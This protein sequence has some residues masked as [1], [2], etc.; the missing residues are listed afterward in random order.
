MFSS[1][2]RS[3]SC[4]TR[5]RRRGPRSYEARERR[6]VD[7]ESRHRYAEVLDA[8]RFSGLYS[9]D[10]GS[11]RS[12]RSPSSFMVSPPRAGAGQSGV[13]PADTFDTEFFTFYFINIR[14]FVSHKAELTATLEEHGFPTFVG[15]NETLLPGERAMR[16]IELP[17]YIL[18]SRRDRTDNSGWGGIALFAKSGFENCVVHLGNSEVAERAWHVLHTD[19][20]PISLALW[21]RRPEPGEVASIRSLDAEM[22][23]YG[24]DTVGT[25]LI[26]DLNVHEAS[27]LKYSSGTSVEGRELHEFCSE[28]GLAQ[29]VDGPTREQNLLDLLISDLGSLAKVKIV[30]AIADHCG[31]FAS[32]SFPVPEATT[33]QRQ[34]FLYARA[35]WSTLQ[36]VLRDTDWLAILCANDVDGSVE[37]FHRVLWALICDHIPSEVI[38]ETKTSHEWLDDNCRR[39]IRLKREAWGTLEFVTRRD[40]CTRGLLEAYD[41]FVK[42][43]RSKL[44]RLKRSSRE[45]WRLS[46]ALMSLGSA[47]E[48]VP[49]LKRDD[50]SWSTSA[51]DKADL[52]AEIFADK[53]TLDDAE[54]NEFSDR[55]VAPSVV[56]ADTFVP[57]RRRHVRSVLKQLD[58]NSG[59][60]PDGISTRVLRRC[61]SE[62]EIPMLLLARL[63]FN[64]GKWPSVWRLHWV[65]PI[66]KKKSRADPRN[67]R[68]VHLTPQ[69]SKI[70]E[71]VIGRAFLPWV[72]RNGLFGANQYAYTEKRSHKDALAANVCNWLVMLEQGGTIGLYCSDVTGAF[73]RVR[74]E[75]LVQKLRV[76]GINPRVVRFLES[77]LE[78]RRSVV[79][80]SG[81]QSTPRLL[82]NSVYQGT[83]LGPPLWNL[84]YVDASLA[85]SSLDFSEVVFADDFNC[86]RSFEAST[87]L[88]AVLAECIK[89]QDSLHKWGRANSVKFDPGKES[90]HILH[91]TRGLGD[92]FQLLGL[93]FD[94]ALQM[95]PCISILAREAGWRL[96]SVLRPRRFFST[97]EVF[98]LYK[99][100]VLSY[101][102]SGTAGYYHAAPT[103]LRPLDRVQERLLREIGVSAEEA[104]FRYR[105]APLRSRRDMAM[106]GLLHRIVLGQAP[107]QLIELFPRSGLNSQP[108]TRLGFRRHTFQL[109]QPAFRTDVLQRS[110]FGLTVVYN[111]L[112]PEVVACSSVKIFQR[113]LQ[114]AL[115][116]AANQRIDNWDAIFSPRLRPIRDLYFQRLFR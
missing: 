37:R 116:N 63:V 74:R 40:E 55:F 104:L 18:V 66:Y 70:V 6:R 45:W 97:R 22:A 30:P 46:R 47:A 103:V 10:G 11:S 32:F 89:C 79:V 77:W 35:D 94:V 82:S 7:R 1:R 42:R 16:R 76:S 20:G 84:F 69:I 13:S 99:S 109:V 5:T 88:G 83:V 67:Y 31:L 39:L 78:D 15:L 90:F 101:I 34:V 41:A 113:W 38:S 8:D 61:R 107:P 80:V 86:W 62:L 68:G 21:Y 93:C 26:G 33:V 72:H 2:T 12:P 65:H 3:C 85:I 14:G 29:Y 60:G 110:V 96:Q 27:W 36:K 25:V 19:R 44:S 106:L 24:K 64:S 81:S 91:R 28:R 98:N 57:I 114:Y 52:L 49:P 102:E 54:E 51:V 50:G 48:V 17:G 4:C 53:A 108:P 75:R 115:R 92:N 87:S 56:Q 58:E 43:T 95:G 100:Q 71:R 111:L 9:P 23:T 112:P 73:D 59:T 105:L